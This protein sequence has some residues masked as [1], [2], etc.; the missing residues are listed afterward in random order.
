[1]EQNGQEQKIVIARRGVKKFTLW[2]ITGVYLLTDGKE[3]IWTSGTLY[4]IIIPLST[5]IY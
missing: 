1:M 2:M 3:T 5:I 4:I